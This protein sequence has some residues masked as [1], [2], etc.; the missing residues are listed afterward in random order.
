[1]S[2]H[3]LLGPTNTGK[4]HRA[5]QRM[6]DH[7]TGMIG[8]PL[9]L[10]A[11]EVYDRVTASVGES[12]VALV[13]GEEKRV[14]RHPRYWVC[15]VEAM[16]VARDVDFLAVDEIQLASHPQRGHVFTDRM[17]HARGLRETWLM[18]SDTM[19]PLVHELLPTALIQRHPRFSTLSG[20]GS[21]GLSA[22]PSRTALVGFSAPQV[23]EFAERLRRKRG[24]AAVV[25][26]ALSPR[27]RNAQVAMYQSGE[28]QYLVATD[29]IGMGLNMDIDLVAFAGLQK[30]D[31]RES[32]LLEAAE[33]AQIAGRAGR[34]TNDGRFATLAPV[35]ALPMAIG[36]AIETHRFPPVRLLMWR[37]ND[38]DMSS[39]DGLVASLK[40]PPRRACL[41]LVQQAD[42]FAALQQLASRESVR[43][44]VRGPE[45]VRLLWSV[46]QIPDFRQLMPEVHASLLEEIF[47]QLASRN[48]CI[49]DDWME[50]RVA[51]LDDPDGDI[52]TL[53]GRIAFIRTWT[54]VSNHGTWVVD[55]PAWQVRTREIEDRLSDAL[56]ERLVQ[57]FVSKRATASGS[58]RARA[59]AP[60]RQSAPDDESPQFHAP[61]QVL[62]GLALRSSAPITAPRTV[63][64]WVQELVEAPHD[65]FHVDAQSRLWDGEERIAKLTRGVDI[66]R[67]EVLLQLDDDPGAGARLRI[68]RRLLAWARDMADRLCASLRSPQ[69]A[70]LSAP[71]RGLVYQLEQGLGTVTAASARDQVKL[72]TPRDYKLLRAIAVRV[73][74][75]LVYAGA[76]LEPQM[77]Q[78]RAALCSA[79]LGR[80]VQA[81][82]A[83]VLSFAP[84][85]GQEDVCLALGYPVFGERAIRADLIERIDGMLAQAASR[86]EVQPPE[87]VVQW[88]GCD[89][90]ALDVVM[91]AFRRQSRERK[92]AG[93]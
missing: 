23:Y 13:T 73:G 22:L 90:E 21:L 14:P 86:G 78:H 17:L 74:P 93:T 2:L 3:A 19:E 1:M 79:W 70:E 57:R 35:P 37:N 64:L 83:G 65:R 77:V 40:A 84:A 32:R 47:V 28:V 89:G 62:K 12:Q 8:L 45:L 38:L 16:P 61:F 75:R 68:T 6:L 5:V 50:A 81:P 91:R 11:R 39:I 48:G 29:A 54:Y 43:S 33:L 26:G 46:C 18:G 41:R 80:S 30:F 85:A 59:R 92:R 51:R 10:L 56:H 31:G 72:L 71:G 34:H 44:V 63:D 49:D 15:T 87:R 27:T 82:R 53:M 66:L 88:L 20:A 25:L 60:Q 67:P 4:T 24:G 55:A 36:R 9:R 42:D 7:T 69:T 52:E 76:M 58:P